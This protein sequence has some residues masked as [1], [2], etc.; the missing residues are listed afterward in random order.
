MWRQSLLRKWESVNINMNTYSV[1]M[2]LKI[3]ILSTLDNVSNICTYTANNIIT[4]FGV[5]LVTILCNR[6]IDKC[7]AIQTGNFYYRYGRD[8][9]QILTTLYCVIRTCPYQIEESCMLRICKKF[10]TRLF[11]V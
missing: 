11:S 9:C 8:F 10:I 5:L 3:L 2:Y 6:Y 1:N 7:R 4:I